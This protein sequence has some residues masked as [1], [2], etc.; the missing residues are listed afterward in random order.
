MSGGFE[1]SFSNCG[2]SVILV[3]PWIAKDAATPASSRRISSTTFTYGAVSNVW[4]EGI[5]EAWIWHE[6]RAGFFFRL[7][8][9]FPTYSEG[10]SVVHYDWRGV[11]LRPVSSIHVALRLRRQWSVSPNMKWVW[12]V[13]EGF[14]VCVSECVKVQWNETCFVYV[15]MF[16][17]HNCNLRGACS[18]SLCESVCVWQRSRVIKGS[19]VTSS[20]GFLVT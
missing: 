18:L 10:Q 13:I 7:K 8:L 3:Q 11:S 9:F 15:W 2:T 12:G 16:Y 5:M 20:S 17:L 19:S 1:A 6:L 14:A 4:L